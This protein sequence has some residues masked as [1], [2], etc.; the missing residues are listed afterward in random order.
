MNKYKLIE[1]E[2]ISTETELG[3]INIKV[4]IAIEKDGKQ[5]KGNIDSDT[6]KT[7]AQHHGRMVAGDTL[8][9]MVEMLIQGKLQGK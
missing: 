6:L 4:F 7:L 9:T 5:I 2:L 3:D 8:L 1:R